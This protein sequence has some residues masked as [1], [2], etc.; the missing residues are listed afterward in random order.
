MMQCRLVALLLVSLGR[1]VAQP[2]RLPILEAI[3]SGRLVPPKDNEGIAVG[4]FPHLASEFRD[5]DSIYYKKRVQLLKPLPN[6]DRVD[7]ASVKLEQL[8]LKIERLRAH[9]QSGQGTNDPNVHADLAQS[10][11]VGA[12]QLVT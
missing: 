2:L 12:V 5:G 9:F 7:I 6:K 11:Q 1:I 8:Q 3:S 10:L 4:V